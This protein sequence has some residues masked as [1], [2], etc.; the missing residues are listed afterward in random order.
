MALVISIM[1][2][3]T[4]KRIRGDTTLSQGEQNVSVHSRSENTQKAEEKNKASFYINMFSPNN[5]RRE[6]SVYGLLQ[7]GHLEYLLKN[8][9]EKKKKI[10]HHLAYDV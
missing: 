10:K 8:N 3:R 4:A 2:L 6:L 1:V 7:R 9:K 5:H